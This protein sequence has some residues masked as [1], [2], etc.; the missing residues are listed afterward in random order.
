MSVDPPKP[1]RWPGIVMAIVTVGIV[2]GVAGGGYYLLQ[3]GPRPGPQAKEPGR[4]PPSER[5]VRQ[6]ERAEQRAPTPKPKP[7]PA[8]PRL[9]RD[10][11]DYYAH[12][13]LIEL[14]PEKPEGGAWDFR[15]GAPDITYLLS[16]NGTQLHQ[17][18]HRDDRLIGEWDLLKLDLTDAVL[19]GE[20]EVATAVN[21]PLVRAS[22]GG[23]LSVTVYDDDDAT[24]SDE[25]GRFDL[26]MKTLR[27]G[28]NTFEPDGGGVARLVLDMV[29][30]DATLP[31][32]LDRASQR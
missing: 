6:R 14:R 15:G 10:G 8:G 31:E 25:A 3:Q 2:A 29:P 12:V 22:D 16:W 17:G 30:R 13:K 28:V 26:P 4:M 18:D 7:K 9:L 11:D 20:V 27:E 24:W 23:S 1:S 5:E 21:A 19:A 32:L